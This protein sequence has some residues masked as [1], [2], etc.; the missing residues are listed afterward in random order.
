MHYQHQYIV[1][2]VMLLLAILFFYYYSTEGFLSKIDTGRT[3]HYGDTILLWTSR[4]AFIRKD[5]SEVVETGGTLTSSSAFNIAWEWEPFIIQDVKSIGNNGPVNYEDKIRLQAW[6]KNWLG[7]DNSGIYLVGSTDPARNIF[8]ITK[9]SL[10]DVSVNNS[11]YVNYGDNICLKNNSGTYVSCPSVLNGSPA[12][13]IQSASINISTKITICDRYGHGAEIEWAKRGVASESS[14][15]SDCIAYYAIDG[16]LGS[17][18]HTN[19]EHNAWWQVKL[20]KDVNITKIN[21]LN[22]TNCCQDRLSDFDVLLLDNNEIIVKSIYQKETLQNFIFDNINVEARIVKIMLRGTNYLHIADVSIFGD[23]AG[24]SQ[25]LEKPMCIDLINTKLIVSSENPTKVIENAD[26]P[27]IGKGNSMTVSFMLNVGTAD[28]DMNIMNKSDSPGL[29]IKN[30]QLFLSIQ[31][32]PVGLPSATNTKKQVIPTGY[33]VI[34]KRWTHISLICKSKVDKSTGWSYGLISGVPY[35]LNGNLR[36]IYKTTPISMLVIPPNWSPSILDSYTMM[37]DL[38]ANN[39]NSIKL[40][41]NGMIIYNHED[42]NM[43]LFNN[44]PI[45]IGKL[46]PVSAVNNYAGFTNKEGFSNKEGFITQEGFYDLSNINR[47]IE[48]K[49][50]EIEEKKKEEALEKREA[51]NKILAQKQL[52]AANQS[53][54]KTNANKIT[55]TPKDYMFYI[56]KFKI[57]NYAVPINQLEHDYSYARVIFNLY[58][59]EPSKHPLSFEPNQLPHI[60]EEYTL[61]FWFNSVKNTII[62]KHDTRILGVDATLGLYYLDG[63]NK[64]VL[65]QI[66]KAGQWYSYC[67]I[68]SAG[69]TIFYINKK[70]INEL[71]TKPLATFS[72]TILNIISPIYHVKYANYAFDVSEVNSMNQRHPEHL[73]RDSISAEWKRI[74]CPMHLNNAYLDL[75][76]PNKKT[77]SA[78][79]FTDLLNEI[80]NHKDNKSVCYGDFTTSL[81]TECDRAKDMLGLE[82]PVIPAGQ[83]VSVDETLLAKETSRLLEYNKKLQEDNKFLTQE[84]LG[85]KTGIYVMSPIEKTY[86]NNTVIEKKA[87]SNDQSYLY[88]LANITEMVNNGHPLIDVFK[89]LN[90]LTANDINTNSIQYQAFSNR[91]KHY[92]DLQILA[93][94]SKY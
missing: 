17:I 29:S 45:I 40:I 4:N 30:N 8:Q 90:T 66:T 72:H 51:D 22:R 34:P 91:V 85:K 53:N 67:E 64:Y 32:A 10:D 23:S 56:N 20:P 79:N 70:L 60:K 16:D 89:M 55:T 77:M 33:N 75:L 15:Y 58:S 12:Q 24:Y 73:L 11:D 44:S 49:Q 3:V 57:Y 2:F 38:P 35:Y 27:Y 92:Y 87:L 81:L 82:M 19:I 46:I 25:L 86:A 78:E 93:N 50:L 63:A 54:A 68:Y 43:P 48:E 61:A 42:D 1:L 9:F 47:I 74:G 7:L 76:S 52:E 83:D 94:A 21:I 65:N 62:Y 31:T 26:V 69:R 39:K 14:I 13:I 36:Q 37:G 18:S 28:V 41:I 88:L 6:S 5:P 59:S 71:P 80:K 84:I